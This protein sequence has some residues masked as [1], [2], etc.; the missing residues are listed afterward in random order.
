MPRPDDVDAGHG[1]RAVSWDAD[2]GSPLAGEPNTEGFWACG[3]RGWLGIWQFAAFTGSAGA[4]P[5][6]SRKRILSAQLPT[7]GHGA[8][9]EAT[10]AEQA[11]VL[12]L[13]K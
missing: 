5:Q 8:G 13:F 9:A 2:A 1:A 6:C 12:R 7:N 11:E 3:P 4:S 10:A